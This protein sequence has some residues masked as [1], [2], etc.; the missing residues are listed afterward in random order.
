MHAETVSLY[1]EM[2][3]ASL[4]NL[5]LVYLASWWRW[6]NIGLLRVVLG[7]YLSREGF[8]ATQAVSVAACPTDKFLMRIDPK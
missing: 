2:A 1:P 6:F 3:R 8:S 4:R 5:M 7:I